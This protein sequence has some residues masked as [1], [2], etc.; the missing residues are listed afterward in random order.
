MLRIFPQ[1]GVSTPPVFEGVL[2][3]ILVLVDLSLQVE[4]F[5]IQVS[6]SFR[7]VRLR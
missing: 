4:N 5:G 2:Q 6:I 7:L 1:A 3:H